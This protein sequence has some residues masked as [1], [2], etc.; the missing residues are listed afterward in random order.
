METHFLSF[1]KKIIEKNIFLLA[2]YGIW[3]KYWF[4]DGIIVNFLLLIFTF[5]D[6]LWLKTWFEK[7]KSVYRAPSRLWYKIC[8]TPTGS[9]L[10]ARKLKF[11]LPESFWPT[12]CTFILRILI[13][14]ILRVPPIQISKKQ[15]T[16]SSAVWLC[17]ARK[18]KNQ[19]VQMICNVW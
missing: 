17:V 11:W 8:A 7:K 3:G 15:S 2:S 13:F 14:D 12:C 19:W 6:F 18:T 4:S 5:H 16:L 10:E 9:P 1:R